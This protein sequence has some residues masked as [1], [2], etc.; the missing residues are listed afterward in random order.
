[1]ALDV[2]DRTA[3]FFGLAV[4]SL[5]NFL[6]PARIIVTGWVA[7]RIGEPL[8]ERAMPHVEAH[9]LAVPFEGTTF[10]IRPTGDTACL[11]AAAQAFEG[12]LAAL[13]DPDL[14]G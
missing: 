4:A 7:D 1:V 12:H 11:G 5:I 2:I 10:S 3:G 13:P 6:N 8:L 9:A 14:P